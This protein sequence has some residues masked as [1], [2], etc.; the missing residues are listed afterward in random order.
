MNSRYEIVKTAD[1]SPTLLCARD[2]GAAEHMHHSGGALSESLFI[3]HQALEQTRSRG[4]PARI[5]SLG[6]GLGYN[7]W[8]ALAELTNNA[9][10]L[11]WSFEADESLR[12]SF[13][14]WLNNETV[15]LAPAFDSVLTAVAK[16]F[17]REPE[18]LKKFG[19]DAYLRRQWQVRARFPEDAQGISDC[20]CIFYD[21][22]SKKM[23]PD[24]WQ[25]EEL[26]TRLDRISATQC[27][28]ATYAAT[29]S[30]NRA[31]KRLGFRLTGKS[32]FLNKRESTLAIRGDIR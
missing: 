24:L 17:A 20:S 23:D 9:D 31:L 18:Q 12:T 22:F 6:L 26:V 29:G 14:N 5:L 4:W 30:L 10:F 32:G 25:E 28:L 19:R 2:H 3:Y 15:E 13:I 11:L 1:G 8:I 16:R 27:V 7:E 21:A